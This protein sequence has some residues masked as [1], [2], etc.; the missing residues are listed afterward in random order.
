[1]TDAEQ[2]LLDAFNDGFRAGRDAAVAVLDREV[3]ARMERRAGRHTN[4][5]VGVLRG[6]SADVRG[7]LVAPHCRFCSRPMPLAGG[8]D[9]TRSY[10][11]AC[12][13]DR[14]RATPPGQPA[15]I[16]GDFL[17]TPTAVSLL[18]EQPEPAACTTTAPASR[19]PS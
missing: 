8:V 7:M 5:V 17:L 9:A 2:A 18:P 6:I 15:V 14:K 19:E 4:V 16:R 13:D 10:C 3:R 1:M 12:S 11:H